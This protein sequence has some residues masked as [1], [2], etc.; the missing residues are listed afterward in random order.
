[1]KLWFFFFFF[2]KLGLDI[3]SELI[4][5]LIIH[6]KR[7][8]H[9]LEFS[10]AI[11][12][13]FVSTLWIKKKCR[14]S[15]IQHSCYFMVPI[16]FY[17]HL[18]GYDYRPFNTKPN[19]YTVLIQMTSWCF[20]KPELI[21]IILIIRGSREA[22][23]LEIKSMLLCIVISS[24]ICMLCIKSSVPTQVEWN[25]SIYY[26]SQNLRLEAVN[27]VWRSYRLACWVKFSADNI[28]KYFFLIFPIYTIWH[29]MQIAPKVTICMKCQIWFPGKKYEKYY[30]FVVHWI[31]LK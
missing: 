22:V 10:N 9:V 17:A 31:S 23:I 27:S 24:L 26:S 29:F 7:Q 28:M 8:D 19:S 21:I 11:C 20:L 15:Q 18:T 3:S 25:L 30:Q 13:R 5:L 2:K 16:Y 14:K 12:Y 1:M 4:A 6:M